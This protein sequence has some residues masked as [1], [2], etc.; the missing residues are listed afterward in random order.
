[1]A[2]AR[3]VKPDFASDDTVGE[4]C[5][6]L[7]CLPLA[8]EL[9]ST[10]VKLMS[11]G[12]ILTRLERRL[13]LLSGGRRDAPGRHVTMRAAIDWSYDLLEP[14]EQRVFRGLAVFAGSFELEAAEKVCSSGIDQLQS[15]ADKSLLRRLEDGRFLLLETTRDYALTRLGDTGE[16]AGMQDCHAQWFFELAQS[17]RA[18]LETHGGLFSGPQGPWVERLRADTDNFR[19][20]LA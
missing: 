14:A 12:Q 5:R 17:F 11:T 7:D 4:I 19:A 10:R 9:A 20:V 8:I 15:L 2:R 13:E 6:C 16:L 1:M 18:D 3:Q